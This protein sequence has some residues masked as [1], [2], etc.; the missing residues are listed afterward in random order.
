MGRMLGFSLGRY[1]TAFHAEI[2]AILACV[3]KIQFQS[4]PEKYV[5]I[6]SESQA[7]L[8]ALQAV[9]TTSPLIQQSQKALN[10]ISTR[11]AVG[12]YWVP[13]HAG[14]RGKEIAEEPAR[15]GSVLKF[16]SPEPALVVS[17]QDIRWFVKQHWI[18]WWRGLGDTQKTGSRVNFRT[19]SWCQGWVSVL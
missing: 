4:R 18:W 7:A 12:L 13:G 6:C 10:V 9:G 8:K 5:S 14:V 16:V 1:A 15:D 11:H 19:L 2:Y 3:Y 17:R